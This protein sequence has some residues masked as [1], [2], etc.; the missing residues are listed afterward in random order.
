MK[1]K[2]LLF[3]MLFSLASFLFAQ[4]EGRLLRFPAIHGS[5]VVFTYAGDLYTVSV[6]GGIARKLTNHVGAEVFPRFSHDGQWIAFTGQYDG[7]TEVYIM[8]AV[9]GVPT[10]ITF[11]ATLD[12][13]DVSDR[14]GPNNIVIGWTPDDKNVLFRSRM[15]E[16]NSFKGQLF[17]AP[18]D[19]NVQTEL[20]LPRGGFGSYS[21]DGKKLAYN[22]IFR[23]FRTWKKYRGGM[24]DD[25]SIYDFDTKETIK[26]AQSPAQDI[27]PM[28]SGDNIFFLSDRDENKRMNLY[29]YNFT[30]G[31]TRKLTNYTDYDIKFPSLGDDAI[32]YEYAGYIYRFDLVSETSKK[33]DVEFAEDFAESRPYMKDVSKNINNYEISPDGKRALFGA[34]GDVFTV[35]VSN[36]IT[37]NLTKT[38]GVFE[39]NS[40]WSPDGKYIAYISDKSG[41]DEIYIIPQDGSGDEIQ[42]TN[43]GGA[44]KWQLSWSPDSKKILFSDRELKLYYVSIDSKKVT[45]VAKGE[46]GRGFFGSW[47]PDSKWITYSFPESRKMN[48]LFVYSLSEGKSYPVTDNWYNSGSPIFSKNGKYIYFVSQRDF[49]PTYSQT[50]WNHAYADMD[51]IYLITLAKDTKSPFG[52][53]NDEVK[54]K[55]EKKSNGND[56]DSSKEV[57]D[58]VIDLDGILNRT[59]KVPVSASNY[60]NLGS[61]GEK[62]YYMRK[63]K[64]DKKPVLLVYDLKEQKE[65]ELGNINGYEISSDKKKMLVCSNN[66]YYIIDLPGNKLDLKEKLDLSGLDVFL[67]LHAEW[68]QVFHQAAR[69]VRD[70]FYVDNYHGLDWDKNVKKYEPF[71]KYVNHRIDLSYIIGEMIGELNIGHAYVGGGDY[72]KADRIKTGLLGAQVESGE[73][74]YY[75]ITEILDGANWDKSLRS[76]LQAIGVNV[77]EGDYIIAVNGKPAPEIKNLF[78]EL[79]GKADKQV[80]LTVNDKPSKEGAKDVTVVPI[81]NEHDLYYYNWV[82]DNIE[83]VDK[84]TNGRVGYVH[85]PDMGVGGLNEFVKQ[86]YPQLGKEALIVDVRGNGGGNVSPMIIERLRREAIMMSNLRNS[87]PS[88]NPSDE[89]VG[90][91]VMLIDEFSAS[92]G[93]IVNYRFKKYGLGTVIGKRS[94]GGVVGIWGSLPYLDHGTLMVPEAGLFDFNG[95]DWLIEGHGIEPDIVVDN[96]PAKEWAGEDQQLNKGIEE[97]MKMLKENP[98]K[99][100]KKAPE[101]PIKVN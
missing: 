42:L 23:E 95:K 92:D 74:G 12:R 50:E 2:S 5:K 17:L 97:I 99:L 47:S 70:F 88:P 32:V 75:K 60:Y 13:D 85:I 48:R 16:F 76:P 96:D 24:A 55:E 22:Q 54:I 34:R 36:G 69:S 6:D 78:A 14:M 90:P 87:V 93:D 39:R 61:A 25:I 83:K 8:P 68:N 101:G 73:S 31:D 45:E 89:I 57:K 56:K 26:V 86:Y 20:P 63:G 94:W 46:V 91:K 71:L 38:S 9:G 41:N 51:G 58:I 7:N 52:P 19:G 35:P 11:T 81:G 82:K 3:V 98:V 65:K 64:A 84:A 30:S 53:K 67:N 59:V 1:R 62:I 72:E 10:R 44:Y 77:K 37:R 43:Q 29:V 79:V 66:S 28:W 4:E 100:P 27:I 49:H 15:Y 80:V 40:K 33:I 18:L 21:P